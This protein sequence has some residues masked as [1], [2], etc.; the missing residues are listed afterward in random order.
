MEKFCKINRNYKQVKDRK[1]GN[2]K[3]AWIQCLE[4]KRKKAAIR[5]EQ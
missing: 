4:E 5:R 2:K 3:A 1:L